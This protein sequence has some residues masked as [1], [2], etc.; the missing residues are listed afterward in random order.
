[1]CGRYAEYRSA[2]EL[3]D[4][5][6]VDVITEAARELPPSWNTAPTDPV[7]MVLDRIRAEEARAEQAQDEGV[8]A[9]DVRSDPARELHLA[10]W[11][12]LPSWSEGPA[13]KGAPLF[14]ARLE[15]VARKP[16]FAKSLLTRRCIVPA[17]GYY[18]WRKN[19]GQHEA[20]VQAGRMR[21]K[22]PFYIR[23]PSGATLA[24][25]GLYAWWRDE[26]KAADDPDRWV[27]STTI[28][29]EGA[30]DG[31][32]AIHDREPVVL[33]SDSIGA[34]L[35]PSLRTAEE[36]LAVLAEPGPPLEWFEVGAAVGSVRN[37]DPGLI[38]PL[39]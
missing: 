10:R 8:G 12:L 15:S 32:E 5:L 11:G 7:R 19:S 9:E 6:D 31:L 27:L 16:A 18:E 34:W 13:A 36:A 1:M 3:A 23:D 33:A 26:S 39:G 17:D 37:N 38:L 30:R 24:F 2:E 22:T 14:N 29:T 4:E 25:A 28:I 20:A 21:P 35:D